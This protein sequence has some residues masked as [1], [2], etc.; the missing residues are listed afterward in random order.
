MIFRKSQ[1]YLGFDDTVLGSKRN[2]DVLKQGIGTNRNELEQLWSDYFRTTLG[3]QNLGNYIRYTSVIKLVGG[4]IKWDKN[5]GLKGKKLKNRFL[6][7]NVIR[8]EQYI[9]SFIEWD[10]L[11]L[12]FHSETFTSSLRTLARKEQEKVTILTLV[13]R[14]HFWGKHSTSCVHLDPG[15]HLETKS[16]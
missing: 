16:K 8:F 13:H 9:L 14:I 5:K 7:A 2:F 1:T 3:A 4:K 12:E 15:D 11:F 6:S 10:T